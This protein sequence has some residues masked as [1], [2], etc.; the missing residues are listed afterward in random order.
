VV[1]TKEIINLDGTKYVAVFINGVEVR[2][3]SSK[4]Q[5]SK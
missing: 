4:S 3:A 5:A 1:T 2:P